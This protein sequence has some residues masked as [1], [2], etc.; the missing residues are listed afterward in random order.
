MEKTLIY[1]PRPSFHS[2]LFPIGMAT[3]ASRL[4]Q[5]GFDVSIL[6]TNV[7][8][9]PPSEVI[10]S[11]IDVCPQMVVIPTSYKLHNNCPPATI[12]QALEFAAMVKSY[13]TDVLTVFVGPL[14]ELTY[15]RLLEEKD[16]DVVCLGEA[17]DTLVDIASELPLE[18]IK[19]IA[20]NRDGKVVRN[21]SREFPDLNELLRPAWDIFETEK[22]VIDSY[23]SQ[24]VL[25]LITSRG[26]P[27]NCTFCFGAQNSE[28]SKGNTGKRYRTRSPEKVVE[29]I[30]YLVERFNIKGLRF[31]DIE[32]CVNK[33]HLKKIAELMY[34]AGLSFL[35]W[36]IVTRVTSMPVD[37]LKT[38]KK[39][40]CFSIYYGVESGDDEILKKTGKKITTAQVL[41]VFEKTRKAGIMPDASFLLGLP[42]E[43]LD[44]VR[45][46]IRFS[47]AIKPFAVIY[48]T[49]YHFPGTILN[50][51][52]QVQHLN[53]LEGKS[54][55][56]TTTKD[57]KTRKIE[58]LKKLAYLRYYL[59]PLNYLQNF[60]FFIRLPLFKYLLSVLLKKGEGDLISQIFFKGDSPKTEKRSLAKYLW[61]MYDPFLSRIQKFHLRIKLRPGNAMF[62]LLEK[63]TPAK[64]FCDLGCGFGLLI[65]L[66]A[67]LR[68]EMQFVGLDLE[69]KRIATAQRTINKRSNVQFMVKDLRSADVPVCEAV[70][71]Y[72]LLHHMSAEQQKKLLKICYEKMPIG[73]KIYVKDVDNRK[74]IR[75][76]F[77]VFLVD[78]INKYIGLNPSEVH[79]YRKPEEIIRLLG[80]AGFDVSEE[81]LNIR[82]IT[83]HYLWIGTKA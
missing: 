65:N 82:D 4:R 1:I 72:D 83:P 81:P 31:E 6:D 19:G 46:S 9:V 74:L 51:I 39:A 17:E 47:R 10:Q 58:K 40:G 69:P 37:I 13:T 25:N 41:E 27:F 48:H 11:V 62:A 66:Q 59:D 18:N 20:Y 5:K 36:R 57:E 77:F 60:R 54:V 32:I 21:K 75:F 26:C 55:Y 44:Q 56:G 61:E 42:G 15:A 50:P 71:L 33:E 35:K 14:N 28:A 45:Q 43:T 8:Y 2:Y 64:S 3:L 67:M 22:Y 30:Q 70:I 23:F 76:F 38:L 29:D 78:L 7:R 80:S 73:G 63:I 52:K 12:N 79:C 53:E 34:D 24:K 49:Y 68:P 16:V